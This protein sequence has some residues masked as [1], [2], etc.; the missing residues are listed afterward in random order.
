MRVQQSRTDV[1]PLTWEI[2]AAIACTWLFLALL[3]LPAGQGIAAWLHGDGFAWPHGHVVETVEG[4]LRGDPASSAGAVPGVLVYAMIAVAELLL[5]VV[6][7]WVMVLWWR[8]AGPGTQYGLAT[9]HQITGV[10]GLSNL[11]RRRR[12]IRPDLHPR[13]T[14]LEVSR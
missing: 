11:R 3:A 12:V 6:A 13:R 4:L 5:A 1:L 14:S 8:T 2:P 7:G 9:R 10:L